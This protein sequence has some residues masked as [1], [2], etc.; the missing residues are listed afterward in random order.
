MEGEM[1]WGVKELQQK[2]QNSFSLFF[3]ANNF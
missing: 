2:L 1:S 3:V